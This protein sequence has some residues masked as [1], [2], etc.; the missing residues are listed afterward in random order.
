M[1]IYDI[2]AERDPLGWQ[3]EHYHFA[4]WCSLRLTQLCAC[5]SGSNE[6]KHAR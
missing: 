6:A 5:G 3:R 1:E 4:W 2:C